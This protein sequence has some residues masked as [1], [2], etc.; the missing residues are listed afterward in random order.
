[1]A[2]RTTLANLNLKRTFASL[3]M[4]PAVPQSYTFDPNYSGADIYPGMVMSMHADGVVTLCD[5]TD[6]HAPLG[7]SAAFVAPTLGV[8]EVTVD[9]TREIGVWVGGP[10]AQYSILAPAFDTTQTW[11]VPTD[12]TEVLLVAGAG[13]NNIGKLCPQP[14]TN[15]TTS[16]YEVQHDAVPI[17]K[18]IS[19]PSASEIIV[20]P[21]R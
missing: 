16:G 20:A 9:P 4:Y 1:M 14:S 21:I 3:Y 10:G 13:A 17:A 6:A 7:F 15:D 11:T 12:G 5:G 19:V 2:F 18:L 8:D